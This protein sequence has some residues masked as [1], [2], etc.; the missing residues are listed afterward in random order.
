V[1]ARA[2]F[3]AQFNTVVA[4]NARAVGLWGSLGF[5]VLAT[6][7]EAFDHR[8]TAT[9]GCTSCTGGCKRRE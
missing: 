4:T 5:E 9:W 3:R 1:G 8:S 6:V 7:P 2:G